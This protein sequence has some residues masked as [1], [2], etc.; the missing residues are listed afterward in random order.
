V[1][2]VQ[3]KAGVHK[4]GTFSFLDMISRVKQR[5]DFRK[6]GAIGLFVGVVRG[7][8]EKGEQVQ[9]LQLEAYEEKANEVLVKI[10]KDLKMRPGIVDIQIHHMLGEFDVGEDLVYVMVAGSHRGEVFPVLEEAVERYKAEAPI[11][12]KEH[13]LTGSGHKKAY[14]LSEKDEHSD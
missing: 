9:R 2:K 1:I 8:T 13:V 7:Q 11:F 10:C 14:W 6:A 12:K 4:K 5:D 3:G